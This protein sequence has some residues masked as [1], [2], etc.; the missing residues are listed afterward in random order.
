MH[1]STRHTKP[2]R[3][4]TAIL[5]EHVEKAE[6]IPKEQK[7]LRKGQRGCLDALAIDATVAMEARM[8]LRDLAMG[9]I[10]SYD[11][12]PHQWS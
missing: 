7:A 1:A 12:V 5:M 2:S 10:D 4:L 6:I 9:W 11:L 8:N 3:A